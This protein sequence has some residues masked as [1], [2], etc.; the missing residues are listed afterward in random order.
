MCPAML[1]DLVGG[2]RVETVSGAQLLDQLTTELGLLS[3]FSSSDFK[4]SQSITSATNHQIVQ[5]HAL[6]SATQ[7]IEC[8]AHRGS[9]GDRMTRM[10]SW[11]LSECSTRY[12]TV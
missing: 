6:P 11:H 2:I 7:R 3:I 5:P 12:S 1:A 8:L 4:L 9:L 10:A